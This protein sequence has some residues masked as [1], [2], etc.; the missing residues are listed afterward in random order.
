[1]NIGGILIPHYKQFSTSAIEFYIKNI[2]KTKRK[3][4]KLS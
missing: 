2:C 4:E 3:K 1:M